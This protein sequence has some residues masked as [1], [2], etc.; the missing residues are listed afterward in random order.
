MDV[1]FAVLADAAET[2]PD[3][4]LSVI[5]IFN[6]I[7]AGRFP[8]EHHDAVLVAVLEAHASEAGRH[9]LHV[10]FVDEDGTLVLEARVEV[11]VP[12]PAEALRPAISNVILPIPTLPLPA[13]GTY[14]FDI[15]L[16][17]TYAAGV[18]LDAREAHRARV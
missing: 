7:S 12:E 16:D 4:K 9:E 17:G 5:G 11:A 2:A 10:L 8:A 6:Q 14:S 18:R 13:T 3:G 1:R 15:L